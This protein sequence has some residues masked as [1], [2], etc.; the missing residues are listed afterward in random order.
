M[1]NQSKNQNKP[2]L[3]F[4]AGLTGSGKSGL[5]EVLLKEFEKNIDPEIMVSVDDIFEKDHESIA[6]FHKLYSFHFGESYGKV[7]KPVSPEKIILSD[8]DKKRLTKDMS[9]SIDVDTYLNELFTGI[10]TYLKGSFTKIND[11]TRITSDCVMN[12]IRGRYSKPDPDTNSCPDIS[13]ISIPFSQFASAIYFALRKKRLDH[14]YDVSIQNYV[15]GKKDVIIETNGENVDSIVGWWYEKPKTNGDEKP[16][17]TC[18]YDPVLA[19]TCESQ[20]T[21]DLKTELKE[22]NKTVCFL[23]REICPTIKSIQ[24]RALKDI[25]EFIRKPKAPVPRLPEID[26]KSLQEKMKGINKTYTT[27]KNPETNYDTI[28]R[29]FYNPEKKEQSEQTEQTKGIQELE[30]SGT[31]NIYD[32]TTISCKKEGGRKTK[33]RHKTKRRRKTKARRR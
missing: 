13:N 8:D 11:E 28:V 16:K 9:N 1:G 29:V 27:L 17:T 19:E 12:Q 25:C 32:I 20:I 15:N 14:K 26:N 2:N 22:Y 10:E 30:V 23:K 3:I 4:M 7:K 33:R 31:E 5:K 18:G 24:D 21:I 6:I